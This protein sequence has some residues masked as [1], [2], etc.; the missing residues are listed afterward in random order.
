MIPMTTAPAHYR[1]RPAPAALSEREQFAAALARVAPV[2]LY[3]TP[4]RTITF[5]AGE[6]AAI[7]GISP[8]DVLDK[9]ALI[10][11]GYA[12]EGQEFRSLPKVERWLR[13]GGHCVTADAVEIEFMRD[14]YE[15]RLFEALY[16]EGE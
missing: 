11:E 14:G 8:A 3:G 1:R 6:L 4:G 16:G 13:A 5:T 12:H 7:V 15:G 9:T 10:A 2:T